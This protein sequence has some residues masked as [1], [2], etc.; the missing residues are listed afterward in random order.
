MSTDSAKSDLAYI[1]QLMAETR[2]ATYLSGGYFV[3]WGLVTGLGLLATW[4]QVAGYWAVS[5]FLIW[6]ITYAL[7]SVGTLFLARQE[8]R[9][10]VEAPAGK[11]IGMV[12]ISIGI[13][14]MIN[15]FVGVGSGA[16]DG[17]HMSGVAS[18]LVGTAV[19]LTGALSGIIWL[20][21]LAAGWWAGSAVI[22]IWPGEH[23][24]LL[25]GFLLL[26]L[27]VV[28]GIVLIQNQHRI[29]TGA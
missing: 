4:A 16:L 10:P 11:L 13:S 15:F 22:F 26:A 9:R 12:W 3:V 21:N 19:F 8:Y 25:M 14:M 7:G 2:Q 6:G 24:F 27:H 18:S 23:V 29:V 20:R 5:P 28:P 1:R 17:Q